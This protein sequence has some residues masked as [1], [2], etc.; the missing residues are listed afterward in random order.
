MTR[1]RRRIGIATSFS[2]GEQRLSHSYV[3]AIEQAGGL[4]LLAPVISSAQSA[5]AFLDLVDGLVIPGG[6]GVCRG[7]IG[8]LPDD[9]PEADPV[10]VASDNVAALVSGYDVVVEGSDSLETKLLVNDAC[11]EL[12]RSLVVAGIL[13][14]EGQLLVVR[15]RATACSRCLVRIPPIARLAPSCETVGI[16][17]P[18]AGVVGAWQAAEALTLCLGLSTPGTGQLVLYDGLAGQVRVVEAR[19]DPGCP[20]CGAGRGGRGR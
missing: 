1:A 14:W 19:R 13:R 8:R 6:D 7:M 10:R 5:S 17:G 16:A 4:P 18:V 20:T 2:D 9:L 3:L 15:P 11:V 12:D